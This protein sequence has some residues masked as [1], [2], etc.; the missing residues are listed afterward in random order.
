MTQ[1]ES[2]DILLKIFTNWSSS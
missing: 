2:I 1:H